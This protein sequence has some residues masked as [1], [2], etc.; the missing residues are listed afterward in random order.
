MKMHFEYDAVWCVR[1]LTVYILFVFRGARK[2][3]SRRQHSAF[4][5]FR[6]GKGDTDTDTDVHIESELRIIA[7]IHAHKRNLPFSFRFEPFFVVVFRSS[8]QKGTQAR[9]HHHDDPI[10]KC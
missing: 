1:T 6:R 4:F 7:R 8:T 5:G 3:Y 2:C 10:A 9:T